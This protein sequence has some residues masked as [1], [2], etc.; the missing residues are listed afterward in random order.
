MNPEIGQKII[1]IKGGNTNEVN[2]KV[3]R[4]LSKISGYCVKDVNVFFKENFCKGSNQ[5]GEKSN[6]NKNEKTNQD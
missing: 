1:L 5:T 2:D 6:E 4:S 3:C